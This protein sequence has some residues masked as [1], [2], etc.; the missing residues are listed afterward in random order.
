MLMSNLRIIDMP[1]HR[2]WVA[3]HG[4]EAVV[5]LLLDRVP[6]LSLRIMNMTGRHFYGLLYGLPGM[7]V[8]RE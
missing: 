3:E 8:R 6:T 4:H 1:G 7:V 5:K 2:S